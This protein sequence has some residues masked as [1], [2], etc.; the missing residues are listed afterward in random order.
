MDIVDARTVHTIY[1]NNKPLCI[2]RT[3]KRPN[4]AVLLATLMPHFFLAKPNNALRKRGL[5][6]NVLF[7]RWLR[8]S[9]LVRHTIMFLI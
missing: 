3:T 5:A 6:S 1:V 9:I 2:A 4:H 7:E 8:N